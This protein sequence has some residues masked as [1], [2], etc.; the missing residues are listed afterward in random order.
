MK[1]ILALT[2]FLII[3]FSSISKVHSIEA[4]VFIQ[5]TVNRAAKTLGGN[6]TKEERVEKL[7]D[8]ARDTVDINGIG[9]YSLGN[10]RKNLTE[11]QLD[12]YNE[13]FTKYF[14][15]SFSSRLAEYSNPEIEVDS[16]KI[17]NKNYTIVSSTLVS[18]D[19]RPE[20]KIEWRVYTKNPNNLLI[21]DLIIEGL[22]LART[23]KEEFSSIINSN[24]GKIEALIKNLSDFS[25]K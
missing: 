19:N 17:I 21:R 22:S 2:T 1:K 6:L 8:I 9:F 10:N 14:L 7:K 16:K 11:K 24:D 25:N 20:V 13:V 23:Q 5:S 3:I 4:D 18:T 12:Q 15:K